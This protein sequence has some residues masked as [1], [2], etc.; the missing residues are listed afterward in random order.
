MAGGPTESAR[1]SSAWIQK[2]HHWWKLLLVEV[3]ELMFAVVSLAL[4]V[5]A[6]DAS[7]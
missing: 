6:E 5:V 1:F 7:D 3:G 4:V 2:I